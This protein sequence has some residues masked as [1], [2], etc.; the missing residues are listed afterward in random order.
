MFHEYG[1]YRSVRVVLA[2]LI[3]PDP[4]TLLFHILVLTASI[5]STSVAYLADKRISLQRELNEIN[6]QLRQELSQRKNAEEKYNHILK[7]AK[8]SFFLIDVKGN[9][10]EVN[11]STTEMLGY[12][13]KELFNMDIREIEAKMS[14]KEVAKM[15]K[16]IMGKGGY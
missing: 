4:L 13:R 5:I 7:T 11:D 16:V 1:E 9:F 3:E 8:D 15:I 14:V 2:E 12:S 6:N 10:K